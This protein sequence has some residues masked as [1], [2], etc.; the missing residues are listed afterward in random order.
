MIIFSTEI[1]KKSLISV[2]VMIKTFDEHY[3]AL[4]S[5]AMFHGIT[6]EDLERVA[7]YKPGKTFQDFVEAAR[8]VGGNPF[9][10]TSWIEQ[11][12]RGISDIVEID[13]TEPMDD[14][15]AKL[16]RLAHIKRNL[17]I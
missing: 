14:Y 6:A 16:R 12:V 5:R 15:Y 4:A 7:K 11:L 17:S 1:V 13:I 9:D 3:E 8:K 2:I 10:N